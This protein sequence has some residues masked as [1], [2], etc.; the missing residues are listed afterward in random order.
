MWAASLPTSTGHQIK[1][2]L[3]VPPLPCQIPSQPYQSSRIALPDVVILDS[4]KTTN[5][6]TLKVILAKDSVCDVSRYI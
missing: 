4:C 6:Q 5:M 1:T 2:L 3:A